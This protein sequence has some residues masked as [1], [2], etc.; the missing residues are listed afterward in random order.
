V[1][2]AAQQPHVL[3]EYAL[4]ADGE[5]GALIGPRGDIAWMCAPRWH[6]DAVF[7]SLIGGRG[8]F[9]ITPC[10][11]YVWGGHYEDGSLI[12]RS[13][14]V[15]S[16]GITECREALAFP[17]D[18]HRVV[19][20]R[21]LLAQR[22]TAHVDVVFSP[23][24]NFGRRTMEDV[25]RD[26]HGQ[27]HGRVGNLRMRLDGL[28]GARVTDD[29]SSLR[30][31]LEITEG[32]HL[33][34]VVELS[35]GPLADHVRDADTLWNDTEKAWNQAVPELSSSTAVR[36][37]RHSYA[38]LRG[39][40]SAGGGMVAAATT[41]LPERAERGR[42]YDYR[43]GWIR[44]QCYAGQ[45]V[46]VDGPHPLLDDAVNF[47][48]ERLLADGPHLKPAYTVD[49]NPVPDQHSLPL[50][51]YPGGTDIVG[52]HANDQFQLDA[53]GESLLL[54]AAAARHD[55][56]GDAAHR[57]AVVAVSAITSRWT[58]PDAGIWE[59]DARYWTHSRL[60]CVAGLRAVSQT[61]SLPRLQPTAF[62]PTAGGN[63]P[64]T[65]RASTPPSWC[66]PSEAPCLPTIPAA[67]PPYG[68]STPNSSRMATSTASVTTTAPLPSPREPS[69][70]AASGRRWRYTSRAHRWLPPGSSNEIGPPAVRPGCSARST[71]WSNANCAE[72]Y[73][74]PSSMR[75]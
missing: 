72:T 2:S 39:L 36:D 1:S 26:D 10:E 66:R 13:R 71:T 33:D 4:L 22:G 60:T 42:N 47:V 65:T 12:W 31:H 69:C 75:C 16:A 27:W 55:R 25:V 6:D 59:L 3:R 54:F 29:G 34:I 64:R 14:W 74:K 18:P 51:G 8:L 38:V 41:S 63:A 21:R 9:S 62:T 45:A 24:A 11:R 73:R 19:L 23:A 68:P 57:A 53:L 49:G 28:A 32:D 48:A 44:D 58:E 20:I 30:A 52:N 35:D 17:G 37:A 5:R 7:S 46:A 56:L 43:Y 15:T 50:P 40:T 61:R 70:S 67:S